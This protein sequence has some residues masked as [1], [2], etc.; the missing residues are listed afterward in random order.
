MVSIGDMSMVFLPPQRPPR[1]SVTDSSAVSW[2]S[3]A[4]PGELA[5]EEL[6]RLIF[7]IQKMQPHPYHPW[8]E[9]SGIFSYMSISTVVDLYG[10]YIRG[11]PPPTNSEIIVW[12]FLCRAPYIKKTFTNSTVSGPGIPPIYTSDMDVLW[13]MNTNGLCHPYGLDPIDNQISIR[14][15]RKKPGARRK[16]NV[17]ILS[18]FFGWG[19]MIFFHLGK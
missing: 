1:S 19:R 5:L 3:Q 11:Y 9:R 4:R 2:N 13:V 12:S 17:G 15:R 10:K 7:S 14:S 18:F 6:I 16:R 8:D